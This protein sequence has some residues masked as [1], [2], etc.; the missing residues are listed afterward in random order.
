[1]AEVEAILIPG[2]VLPDLEVQVVEYEAY[3]LA[4]RR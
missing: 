1:M 2:C 4:L 3:E